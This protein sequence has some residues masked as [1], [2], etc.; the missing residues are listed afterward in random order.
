MCCP[1]QLDEERRR[2]FDELD[3]LTE[4]YGLAFRVHRRGALAGTD[5]DALP[6]NH[7]G[8][9]DPTV[10]D[11]HELQ[12]TPMRV[13][14]ER[15]S[16]VT[17]NDSVVSH[18]PFIGQLDEAGLA[19]VATDFETSSDVTS[20]FYGDSVPSMPVQEQL[21]GFSFRPTGRRRGSVSPPMSPL[22]TSRRRSK[23]SRSSRSASIASTSE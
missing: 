12:E 21:W 16:S 18:L 19:G 20:S 8:M 11:T 9:P 2:R 10:V 14:R 17:S 15:L 6:E 7:R 5:L 23:F 3:W 1:K 22:N 13:S 4:T